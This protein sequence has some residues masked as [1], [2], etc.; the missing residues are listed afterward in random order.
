MDTINAQFLESKSP[1]RFVLSSVTAISH[2]EMTSEHLNYGWSELR[3]VVST[4]CTPHFQD[5]PPNESKNSSL[6]F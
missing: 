1:S 3:C 6:L 5:L 4:T 2:I